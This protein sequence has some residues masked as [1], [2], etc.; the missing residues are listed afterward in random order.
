M[1]SFITA[2]AASESF[3]FPCSGKAQKGIEG[4]VLAT[5]VG[6]H[7]RSIGAGAPSREDLQKI[8]NVNRTI[9]VEIFV[10]R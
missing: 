3:Y 6:G 8:L 1:A 4:G 2:P 5:Q 10:T 9:L 7:P